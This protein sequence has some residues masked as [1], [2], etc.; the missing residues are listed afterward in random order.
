MPFENSLP[1]SSKPTV[2]PHCSNDPAFLSSP[3]DVSLSQLLPLMRE[4]LLVG[5]QSAACLLLTDVAMW[6]LAPD[7]E[8]ISYQ[9]TDISGVT[10]IS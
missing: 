3:T 7:K 4:L 1:S 6:E 8:F 2:P 10:Q 9:D 5:M